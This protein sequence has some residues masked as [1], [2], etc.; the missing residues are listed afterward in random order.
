MTTDELA[1][2][3]RSYELVRD[4]GINKWSLVKWSDM[5]LVPCHRTSGG[6]RRYPA[7]AF[8]ICRQLAAERA[9]R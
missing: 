3:H 6:H 7:E 9:R 8:E 5:G 1:N 4:T 2:M